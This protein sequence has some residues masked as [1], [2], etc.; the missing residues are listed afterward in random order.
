MYLSRKFLTALIAI[1][2]FL[3]SFDSVR[4]QE[5]MR[6]YFSDPIERSGE[7]FGETNDGRVAMLVVK[8][9]VLTDRSHE[10]EGELVIRGN[11]SR[12]NGSVTTAPGG[13]AVFYPVFASQLN[14]IS[15]LT[16]GIG[17]DYELSDARSDIFINEVTE[18]KVTEFFYN[19]Q[20]YEWDE[21]DR[22]YR[23]RRGFDKFEFWSNGDGTYEYKH[24]YVSWGGGGGTHSEGTA[25]PAG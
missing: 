7:Y 20:N 1:V 22:S 16:N 11:S 3:L 18:G 25:S 13:N 8:R 24:T 19:G 6:V 14:D 4:A 5:G 15:G 23:N 10:I 12:V 21:E 17:S 9:I 2:V